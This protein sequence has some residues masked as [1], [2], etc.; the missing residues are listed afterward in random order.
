M[1]NAAAAPPPRRSSEVEL[2]NVRQRMHGLAAE[3]RVLPIPAPASTW[4]LGFQV[5]E[6]CLLALMI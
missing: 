1:T 3:W 5:D 2:P 4:K 6:I